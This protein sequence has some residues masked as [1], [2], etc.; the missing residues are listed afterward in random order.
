MTMRKQSAKKMVGGFLAIG[1]AALSSGCLEREL[2]PLNPCLVS[3]VTASIAV[4]NVDKVDILF[5]VDNSNSMAQEQEALKA[6]FPTLINVLTSGERTPGDPMPFPPAKDLHLGV[7]SSDMGLVGVSGVSLCMGFGDDGIM[8]DPAA[9]GCSG[10]VSGQRFLSYTAGVTDPG[11]L[12]TNFGCLATLGTGGCGFEQQLESTLKALW[13][14]NDFSIKTG[15]PIAKNRIDFLKDMTG[16]GFGH[17]DQE[18]KGFLRNKVQ[19]GLSLAAIVIVSDEEDCSSRDTS[20][21]KPMGQLMAN[22]PNYGVDLNVRCYANKDNLYEI[23]TEVLG[24]DGRPTYPNGRYLPAFKALREGSENLVV[25]AAIVG[26]PPELVSKDARAK[27]DFGNRMQRRAYYEGILGADAMQEVV[28]ATP[29][30][31][32]PNAKKLRT[33][34]NTAAGTAYPPRRMVELAREFG[35]NAVVQSICNCLPLL[36]DGKTPAPDCKADFS[37]AVG[38]IIEVIAKQLGAVC[39]PKPLTRKADGMV[40]CNVVWELP[41]AGTAPAMTPTECGQAAFLKPVSGERVA[42]NDRG[43]KNCDVTQ[44]PTDPSNKVDPG[45]TGMQGWFYDDFTDQLAKEC[46]PSTPH[47]IA[48]TSAAKPPTGVTV[49]LECLDENQQLKINSNRDDVEQAATVPGTSKVAEIGTPCAGVKDSG[50]M[51]IAGDKVCEITLAGGKGVDNSMFCHPDLNVCVLKCSSTS[52]CPSAW[53]CDERPATVMAAGGKAY[54]VNPTCG[55][56]GD[57]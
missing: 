49:K 35:E 52:D 5:M 12:A 44:L 16:G 28:V 38:A 24:M 21:F 46:S 6:Q 55:A 26:V 8:I 47:R 36:P 50:G 27:V 11:A 19:D 51:P 13:P 1:L 57:K 9:Q 33:S 41:K 25:Y 45:T 22:D 17:G 7:V 2:K 10:G 15:E 3:G 32:D 53:E 43:G 31:M 56:S 4:S 40:G 34:C 42:V 20:H 37:D 54:C 29:T 48:F 23:G 30:P 18:N 14:R 39:L